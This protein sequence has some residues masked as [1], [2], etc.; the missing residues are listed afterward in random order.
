MHVTGSTRC[1]PADGF[2]I[3]WRGWLRGWLSGALIC[4]LT[5]FMLQSPAT[6]A[7]QSEPSGVSIPADFRVIPLSHKRGV[8]TLGDKVAFLEDRHHALTPKDVM[9]LTSAEAWFRQDTPNANLGYSSSAYWARVELRL[10]EHMSHH[11]AHWWLLFDYSALDKIDVH[12]MNDGKVL[13]TLELGDVR[14]AQGGKWVAHHAVRLDELTHRIRETNGGTGHQRLTMLIRFESSSSY[15]LGMRLMDEETLT[16][17][18][19]QDGLVKGLFYGVILIMLLYNLFI[20]GSTRDP[21]YGWYA[22][23]VGLLAL[24]QLG[25]DGYF[26]TFAVFTDSAWNN[27]VTPLLMSLI[28]VL[29]THFSRVF[30]GTMHYIWIDRLLR[31]VILTGLWNLVLCFVVP[32]HSMITMAMS[33]VVLNAVLL[34]CVGL[35]MWRRGVKSARFFCLAWLAFQTGVLSRVL[36]GFDVLPANLLTSYGTQLGSVGFVALLSFALADR[37]RTQQREIEKTRRRAVQDKEH[38]ERINNVA[39]DHLRRYRNLFNNASEGIFQISPQRLFTEV[40]PAFARIFGFDSTQELVASVDDV[41]KHCFRYE[42]DFFALEK[43]VYSQGRAQDVEVQCVRHDGKLFWA[44]CSAVLA[45]DNSG[46]PSHIEG[47]LVDTTEKRE[48]EQAYR[49]REAALASERA[50]SEFFANLSHEIRTPINAITG[51]CALVLHSSLNPKQTKFVRNIETASR[52]LLGVVN[53]V[54]DYSKIEAGKLELESVP[55][56]LFTLMENIFGILARRAEEKGIELVLL[57]QPEL[58]LKWIGDPLRLEQILINL[59]SNAIKFSEGGLVVVSVGDE[60]RTEES[61]QVA[62]A[63]QDFGVGIPADQCERLFNPFS[64]ADNSTTRKFGG[65]GLGLSIARQLVHMMKGQI[66][67]QSE[68]GKGATFLFNVFLGRDRITDDRWT[69]HLLP[70]RIR[71]V[72]IDFKD[73]AQEALVANFR[74]YGCDVVFVEYSQVMLQKMVSQI[75]SMRADLLVVGS[76]LP[77]PPEEIVEQLSAEMDLGQVYLVVPQFESEKRDFDE[78]NRF[79]RCSFVI[80]KPILPEHCL[81]LLNDLFKLAIEPI[82]HDIQLEQQVAVGDLKGVSVLLVE[83][84]PFNQEVTTEF[85]DLAGA[86][87][88]LACNGKDAVDYVKESQAGDFDLVLMDCQMPVMDGFDATRQIRNLAQGKEL[89]IIAMTAN[90]MQGDRERCLA[91]GMDDYMSKPITKNGLY[92]TILNWV[93]HAVPT[94][95]VS[96]PTESTSA[97][98]AATE[99]API[100]TEET[101]V[102]RQDALKMEEERQKALSMPEVAAPAET[103]RTDQSST[104]KVL[105]R[106]Q[107]LEL[108]GGSE[109]LL[110][111]MLKRFHDEQADSVERIE[112][113]IMASDF[114][115]AHRVAHTLKGISASIA[116]GPLNKAVMQLDVVLKQM[117]QAQKESPEAKGHGVS[118]NEMRNLIDSLVCDTNHALRQTLSY[119]ENLSEET[120]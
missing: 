57:I 77:Q 101:L 9:T 62:F 56:H 5:L 93:P 107:A 42:Q 115:T 3:R 38:I 6:S 45:Y 113:A 91:A 85:L 84:T 116:A 14:P 18:L 75:A 58:P 29:L 81:D 119:I 110:D 15:F 112:A 102:N 21:A 83:D 34:M 32:Y 76:R 63:V 41:S 103:A 43:L 118:Q 68:L 36:L 71:V 37:I 52:N 27:Q 1:L 7:K 47:I 22:G 44:S 11:V 74:H 54:L 80:N 70:K 31:F 72:V 12:L 97:E 23:G 109:A 51:Y 60:A 65:T 78:L 2:G 61:I 95:Q 67:V 92:Q 87:V 16:E 13:E 79:V 96:T 10:S 24:M 50:K 106:D 8:I 86:T 35:V 69:K 89:P 94:V 48:K 66:S 105:R 82:A 59:I 88:T 17:L 26:W 55:F 53:D 39:N 46:L 40:N 108:M 33:L 117:V 25:I 64:Q 49:E 99:A 111:R 120:E 20:F 19:V 28:I 114:E 104:V 90:A 30:L 73:D 4:V 100:H 98:S